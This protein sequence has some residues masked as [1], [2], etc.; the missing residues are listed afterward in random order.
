[1][2]A[3][4]VTKR[5]RFYDTTVGKKAVMAVTGIVLFGFLVGH[6]LGNLQVFA[7]R[8]KINGYAE[9]LHHSTGLLWGTRAALLLAVVLHV[10]AA[11]QLYA[12]KAEARPV[13]YAKKGHRGASVTSRVMIYTG[14]LL[15]AFIVFH[16]LH[17]TTGTVHDAFVE[18]DVF[19]NVTS[20]FAQ[21]AIAGIY[22]VAMG[23]LAMHLHHGLFGMTQSLGLAHPTHAARARALSV[24]VAI[25]LALGF[26]AIPAAV[27][28]GLVR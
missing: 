17:F 11:V 22:L 21:P 4:A 19:H 2:T 14:F 23:M 16:L 7:G 20:A 28:A 24:V 13:A 9:F 26:A 25:V 5:A 12:L 8:E 15:L 10:R 3:L 18:G 1:M 6:M 27:L